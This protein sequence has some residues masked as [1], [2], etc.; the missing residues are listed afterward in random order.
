MN[1]ENT[2]IN[3]QRKTYST[4]LAWKKRSKGKAALMID[5]ARRVG[6][7]YLCEQFAKNEYGSYI[8]I[9]FGN[10]SNEIIDLFNN[11]S[12]NLDYSF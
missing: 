3:L 10:I 7:S 11:D 4:M 8:I 9:D 12:Y 6:K 2:H 1:T 5:G